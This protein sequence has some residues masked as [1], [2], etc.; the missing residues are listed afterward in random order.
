MLHL[1]GYPG[2]AILRETAY[3]TSSPGL[4][5]YFL[6]SLGNATY[7]GLGSFQTPT[8]SGTMSI[9]DPSIGSLGPR[10]IE[11][12]PTCY[13]DLVLTSR[14]SL[15]PC[16]QVILLWQDSRRECSFHLM[17]FVVGAGPL[18]KRSLLSTFLGNVHHLRIVDICYLTELLPIDVKNIVSFIKSAGFQ[19]SIVVQP[20]S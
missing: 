15:W 14:Q 4:V 6:N 16:F 10:C 12:T 3:T 11:G 7:L 13:S 20:L 5:H 19:C 17:I 9:A 2:T 18:R 8:Y 1:S